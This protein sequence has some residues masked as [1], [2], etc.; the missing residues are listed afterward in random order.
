[1][2]WNHQASIAITYLLLGTEPQSQNTAHTWCIYIFMMQFIWGTWQGTLSGKFSKPLIGFSTRWH[3]IYPVFVSH[4]SCALLT[5]WSV[6]CLKRSR[7]LFD[8]LLASGNSAWR[9]PKTN[10]GR[11]PARNKISTCW[12]NLLQIP[13]LKSN[14]VVQFSGLNTMFNKLTANNSNLQAR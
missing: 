11:L 14:L 12:W 1:M 8:I 6:I 7:I 9:C 4:K 13:E 5:R 10:P 2:G 3:A